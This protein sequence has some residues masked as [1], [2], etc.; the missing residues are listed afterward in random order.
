MDKLPKRRRA[1]PRALALC[2]VVCAAALLLLVSPPRARQQQQRDA[3]RPAPTPA[4]RRT[5]NH[6]ESHRLGFGGA[7]TLYGAPD[8]SVSVEGWPRGEVDIS[9]DVELRA[10]TEEDLARLASVN[11][12]AVTDDL[13]HISV[14]TV[15]T[16]DRKYMKRAARDFPKKLLGLPWKIDY[17][18]RVP[19]A[20]DLEIFAGR[21]PLRISGVEGA[22]RLNAGESPDAALVFTGGDVEA[23]IERGT[24]S[25]RLAAQS[26]RGRGANI[27]LGAGDLTV[28]LPPN[29]NGELDARVLRAGRVEN[30]HPA[31]TPRERT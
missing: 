21:G 25:F 4:L 13:N 27:R 30:T 29:F 24:V 17:A 10:D 14:V 9:A 26:W 28:E 31:L 2:A 16:H 8:G 6:R 20:C 1:T 23:T 12:F 5:Q 18:V 15:G 7:L 11:R 19:A 22:L 3:A